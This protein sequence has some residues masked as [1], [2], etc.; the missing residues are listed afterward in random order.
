MTIVSILIMG[1]FIIVL[2]ALTAFY[3]NQIGNTNDPIYTAA[4]IS[5]FNSKA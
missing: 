1:Y 4:F 2:A 5:K 3:N